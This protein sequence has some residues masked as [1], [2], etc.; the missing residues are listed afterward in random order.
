MHENELLQLCE[1]LESIKS[2]QD[3]MIENFECVQ[4]LPTVALY[5]LKAI[6]ENATRE[7]SKQ[8][9][10]FDPESIGKAEKT[11]S[12]NKKNR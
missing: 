11:M 10:S 7:Y 9:L 4:V 1:I 2:E 8:L 3:I 12:L 6:A 5:S